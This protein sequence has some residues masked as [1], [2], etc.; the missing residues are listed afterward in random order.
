[1]KK[2]PTQLNSEST[3]T[4]DSLQCYL[5]CSYGLMVKAQKYHWDVTG[6]HFGP[7][8]SLFQEEY[9]FFFELIDDCA[10]RIRQLGGFPKANLKTISD[11][12][13]YEVADEPLDSITQVKDFFDSLTSFTE[14]T[15]NLL[16]TLN[17][18]RDFASV[19]WLSQVIQDLEKQCWKFRA[20]QEDSVEETEEN[21]VPDN[22]ESDVVLLRIKQGV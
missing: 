20:L 18:S 22:E 3:S 13:Q 10:E 2:L 6:P 7:L 5:A 4:V 21:S 9:E 14:D 19:N 8:H 15:R 12:S 11:T 16:S 1:M 17:S